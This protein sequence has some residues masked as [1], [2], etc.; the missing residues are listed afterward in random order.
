ME[1]KDELLAISDRYQTLKRRLGVEEFAHRGDLET[2]RIS[3]AEEVWETVVVGTDVLSDFEGQQIELDLVYPGMRRSSDFGLRLLV[4][5]GFLFVAGIGW[6]L[7]QLGS[8]G[9]WWARWPYVTGVG[10]G[11]C[12]WLWLWPSLL[13]LVII[14]ISALA[15]IV[16]SWAPLSLSEASSDSKTITDYPHLPLK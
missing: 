6:K 8:L 5:L 7:K 3:G 9:E 4:S 1:E 13:G 15:A 14:M 2:S 16:P 10:L 11:L 12:W